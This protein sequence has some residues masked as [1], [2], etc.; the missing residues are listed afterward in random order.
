M[1]APRPL[2]SGASATGPSPPPING[3]LPASF[4]AVPAVIMTVAPMHQQIHQGADHQEE[5]GKRRPRCDPYGRRCGQ[6]RGDDRKR[7]GPHAKGTREFRSKPSAAASTSEK[8]PVWRSSRGSRSE[9]AE[10][11]GA[12]AT[13]ALISLN[14]RVAGWTLRVHQGVKKIRSKF[15]LRAARVAERLSPSC[16]A[17]RNVLAQG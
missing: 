7:D 17:L 15:R 1:R 11:C 5:I 2:R 9:L 8:D 3:V 16:G 13:L 6:C 4:P 14:A 10:F 12:R